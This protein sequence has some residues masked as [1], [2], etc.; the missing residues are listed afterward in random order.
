M[1]AK[2]VISINYNHFLIDVV[3]GVKVME[4]L[5]KATLMQNGYGELQEC[6][7]DVQVSINLVTNDSYTKF[8]RQKILETK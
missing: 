2:C 5:S 6:N 7:N 4:L 8:E 3:D 1:A